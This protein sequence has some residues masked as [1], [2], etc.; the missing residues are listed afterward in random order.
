[1]K[2]RYERKFLIRGL[3]KNQVESIIKSHPGHFSEIFESRIINNIYFDTVNMSNFSENIIGISNRSKIRIR[4]YGSTFGN[5]ENPLLEIKFK[6]GL[7]GR[8]KNT[9]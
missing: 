3:E 8:K 6:K 2:Y 9:H 1:M 4:W 5:V 7:L